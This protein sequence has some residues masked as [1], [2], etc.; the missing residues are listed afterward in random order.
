M[1][2][3]WK[4]EWHK[5][6]TARKTPKHLTSYWIIYR[7]TETGYDEGIES[8]T[9]MVQANGTCYKLKDEL[10]NHGALLFGFIFLAYL[11]NGAEY[12]LFYF[13]LHVLHLGLLCVFSIVSC[14]CPATLKHN[15]TP[16]I[17]NNRCHHCPLRC[18][19][20]LAL[21]DCVL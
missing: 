4:L 16:C 10:K 13:P 19:T 14:F 12:F 5:H 21:N 11:D 1:A 18:L 2:G 8:R 17:V 15:S 9:V 20:F 3:V 7:A 6:L